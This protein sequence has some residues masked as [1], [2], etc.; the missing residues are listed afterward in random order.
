MTD[1]PP[2]ANAIEMTP[3]LAR[4]IKGI[5]LSFKMAAMAMTNIVEGQIY[6]S[7]PDGRALA[8]KGQK[9]GK[10][11][12]LLIKD[13][14]FI[15]RVLSQGDIG[16][17]EGLMAGE[18]DTP[19][20]AALLEVFSENLDLMPRL[21]LGGPL[22]MAINRFRH[23]FLKKNTKS[24]SKKNILAHYDLGNSFYARWLDPSMTYS[25]A[26]YDGAGE[27]LTTA[28]MNKYRALAEKVQLKAGQKVLEIGCGWGGFA[29]FAAREY[30]AHVTGVTISNEQHA[31]ATE[32]LAKAGLSHL[33]DIQ[34]MDYRDIKGQFDA[35]VSIE[36][37]EAVGEQYW[38]TYFDKVNAV[39]KPGGAAALQ[40]ITIDERLFDEYRSRADFIQSYV[41]PGGMLP[42]VA[43]LQKEVER[44]GLVWGHAGAFG[45]SYADTLAQWAKNFLAEWRHIREM[46][47]DERFR[48]LWRFYLAYCE[49]GFRTGRI[50]VGHFSMVKP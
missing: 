28:Q 48:Q 9:P 11:A 23:K 20:L 19:D 13:F 26:V 45:L 41:F 33:T 35:V 47:F 4:H 17:A 43:R 6:V 3:A 37:F 36:M 15:K 16:F 14:A 46:G 27:D 2:L 44:A 25:S 10:A 30:G 7:L 21:M 8:F 12:T 40:I 22:W 5:P 42:T 49:A 39:L 29:E 24:G 38:A 18:W 34:L 32:R 1:L 31:Y 50:D